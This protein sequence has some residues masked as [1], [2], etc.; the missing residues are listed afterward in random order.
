MAAQRGLRYWLPVDGL[1][2]ESPLTAIKADV[3]NEDHYYYGVERADG[4]WSS[5]R[6][7][8]ATLTVETADDGAADLD[9]AWAI[10]TTLTYS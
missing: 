10:R 5:Y 9:A 6:Y 3:E 7:P 1:D 2:W 4:S 8:K